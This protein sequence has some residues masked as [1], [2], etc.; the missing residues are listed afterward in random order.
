MAAGTENAA[1]L[2]MNRQ[3]VDPDLKIGALGK[4]KLKRDQ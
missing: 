3:V 1:R 2:D 4:R